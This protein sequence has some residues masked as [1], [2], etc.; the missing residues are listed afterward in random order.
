MKQTVIYTINRE[1]RET[2]CRCRTEP[3]LVVRTIFICFYPGAFVE[4]IVLPSIYLFL[5]FLEAC[6]FQKEK[7]FNKL[8]TLPNVK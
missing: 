6:L 8:Y 3:S 7:T 2:K 4:K 1:E 5:H